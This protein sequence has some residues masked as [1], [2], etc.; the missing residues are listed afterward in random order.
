[1]TNKLTHTYYWSGISPQGKKLSGEIDAPDKLTAISM[2]KNQP[3]LLLKLRKKIFIFS[4]LANKKITTVTILIFFRQLVTLIAAGVPI[5]QSL[6]ILNQSN[7][8]A[9]LHKILAEIKT[10]LESGKTLTASLRKFP[11]YFDLFTC[12]LIHVGEQTGTLS[13]MLQRIT[14]HKETRLRLKKKI[15]QSLFYPI[16]VLIIAI[17][18]CLIMLIF[19]I[20]RFSELFQSMHSTLPA[21]T[22]GVIAI[23]NG[24]QHNYFLILTPILLMTLYICYFKKSPFLTQKLTCFMSKMPILSLLLTKIHLA[25]FARNLAIT[26]SAGL[27]ISEGLK[28][29]AE[30]S[31]QPFYQQTIIKLHSE[32][33]KGQQLYKSMQKISTFPTIMVQMVKVGEESGKIEQMLEKIAEIYEAESDHLLTNLTNALEPLIMVIL[34]ALIGILVIAMYLPIFKLGNLM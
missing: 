19:V 26:C 14:A 4:S 1:M 22:R 30:T 10:N 18:I 23:S 31:H 3:I 5:V 8:N 16:I 12:Q 17:A 27:P 15:I 33:L 25:H 6:I 11:H 24:F 34:G 28:I 29:I 13:I 21:L 2:I 7:Q 20:P 32:I 9:A